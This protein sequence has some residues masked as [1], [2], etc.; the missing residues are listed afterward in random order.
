MKKDSE[1]TK[2]NAEPREIEEEK[3]ENEEKDSDI[4]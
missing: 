3:V 4:D 2:T 1:D